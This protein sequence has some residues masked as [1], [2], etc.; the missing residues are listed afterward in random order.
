MDLRKLLSVSQDVTPTFSK[1]K[2]LGGNKAVLSLSP[3]DAGGVVVTLDDYGRATGLDAANADRV[4]W[5]TALAD[6]K[7]GDIYSGGLVYSSGVVVCAVDN[8]LYGLDPG[9]GRISWESTFG[10]FLGGDLVPINEGKSVAVNTI[11]SYLYVFD[12][13][14]GELSWHRGEGGVGVRTRSLLSVAYSPD[15]HHVV[16]V[17][18]DGRVLCLDSYGGEKIWETVLDQRNMGFVGG[19]RVSPVVAGDEVFLSNDLG[20]LLSI[21]MNTGEVTWSLDVGVRDISW[22]DEGLLYIITDK[23]ELLAFDSES[24]TQIWAIS[25]PNVGRA[26]V[27]KWNTPVRI[28]DRLWILSS[29][30]YLLGLNRFSGVV[31]ESYVTPGSGGFVRSPVKVGSAVYMSGKKGLVVVW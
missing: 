3:V 26:R 27:T 12:V 17:L 1:V 19:I 15:R 7:R 13:K 9:T 23:G 5:R 24:K 4:L 28:G 6:E 8:K 21:N 22:S 11:D 16:V 25:L 31:E 30:G 2:L 20:A 10:N 14:S 18:P 29:C